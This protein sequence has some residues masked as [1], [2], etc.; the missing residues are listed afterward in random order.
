MLSAAAT[1]KIFA[2]AKKRA[3]FVPALLFKAL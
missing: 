1:G 2:L 3:G